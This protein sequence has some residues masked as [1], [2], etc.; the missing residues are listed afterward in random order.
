LQ[1]YRR[2][3]F[4]QFSKPAPDTVAFRRGSILLGNGEAYPNRTIVVASA[5]L[6]DKSGSAGPRA[7]GNGEEVRPL[8]KPIHDEISLRAAQPGLGAQALAAARAACGEN[9]AAARR[10]E[11][12]TEAMAA[13]AHQF[14]GLICPLHGSFS[15]DNLAC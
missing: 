1:R 5:A 12:G 10:G 2:Q 9:L 7:I 11:A 3:P 8:P 14:A 6:H 4:H 15:A 13:L